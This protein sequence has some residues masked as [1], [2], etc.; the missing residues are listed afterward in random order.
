[1]TLAGGAAAGQAIVI[2]GSPILLRL[3]A[4]DEIGALSI[5]LAIV[6]IGAIVVTLRY[7]AAIPLPDLDEDALDV[8]LLAI[9]AALSISGLVGLATWIVASDLIVVAIPDTTRAA[10]WLVPLGLFSTAIQQSLT[11]WATRIA[12]FGA[13]ARS[14]M[15][16]GGAQMAGQIGFGMAGTGVLGLIL[17]YLLGRAGGI[18]M[19]VGT[20]GSTRRASMRGT[21]L[22]RLRGVASRYRRF[23]LYTLWAALL[24]TASTQ[25]PVLL[26]AAMFDTTVVGWFSITLRV[27]QLPSA[28]VGAS[29]AQVFY[30]RI[31]R[32]D[33]SD[34]AATT[35][36]V[37][38][39]LA[40]L[41]AG[42]MVVLAVAGPELFAFFFGDAW[43]EAGTYAQWLAPWL[44]LV[45][46][47]SPL[48]TLVFVRERQRTE[49]GFQ[50]CLLAVRVATLLVGW[51]FANATTAIAL[52]GLASAA[53]WFG[54]MLW[55]LQ[56]AGVGIRGPLRWLARD[57][58]VA[59]LLSAP[60]F[61]LTLA[62]VQGV[63]W[64]VAL[65]GTLGAV[66]LPAQHEIRALQHQA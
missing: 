62:G 8:L 14:S 21:S 16:S 44:L 43:R 20:L 54:Y 12:A 58:G 27:L 45:F 66:L 29:V 15:A 56:I 38:R 28:L 36:S 33:D 64:A 34:T 22:R 49:L 23:P 11:F 25:A 17:G 18:L 10:L 59:L 51:A 42:P 50:I 46:V 31:S 5:Y 37:Y 3:Y 2:L 13:S 65:I 41:G 24:N 1:M 48:S 26:L 40:A 9:I 52:F 63:V 53:L 7:E 60:L 61:V 30:A 4:P 39:A 6:S 47:V 32:E 35:R 55:L 19:F 57:V